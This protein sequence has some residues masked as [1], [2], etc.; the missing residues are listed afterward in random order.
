[1]DLE[2]S[3]KITLESS[4][5]ITLESSIKITLESSIKIT[6]ESSIKIT[7]ERMHKQQCMF[8]SLQ[9]IRLIMIVYFAFIITLGPF[10]FHKVLYLWDVLLDKSHFIDSVHVV[11]ALSYC[12]SCI[13]PF[14]YAFASRFVL[15]L[16][17]SFYY[18]LRQSVSIQRCDWNLSAYR[19]FR[20]SFARALACKSAKNGGIS[21][22]KIASTAVVITKG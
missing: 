6:L 1:M 11:T 4:I 19:N 18:Q 7:L 16:F 13:N 10:I 17:S 2:S 20:N 9:A 15:E 12:N 21:N 22:S 14:L 3:I 8:C 5:K